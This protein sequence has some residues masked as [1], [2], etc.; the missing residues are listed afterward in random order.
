MPFD[1]LPE[2]LVSDLVKL[3]IALDGVRSGWTKGRLGDRG[4]DTHCAIGWLLIAAEWD[5]A[6][7]TR[8]ALDYVY[9]ALPKKRQNPSA[10]LKSIWNYNDRGSE[11]RIVQLFADAVRL[12]ETQPA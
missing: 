4:A 9:P 5:A 2:S 11:R 12:A 6:E 10:R 8:L 3:R 1:C 7:A